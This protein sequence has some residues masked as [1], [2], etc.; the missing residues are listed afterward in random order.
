MDARRVDIMPAG[1]AFSDTV[2]TVDDLDVAVA[3]IEVVAVDEAVIPARD[4]VAAY[5]VAG[6]D[7]DLHPVITHEKM[8]AAP[9]DLAPHI[10]EKVVCIKLERGGGIQIVKEKAVPE[11]DRGMAVNSVVAEVE[12]ADPFF[13]G[14]STS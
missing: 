14:E 8:P 10:V 3:V 11:I 1:M 5:P 13:K 2:V 12:K 4:S 9:Q 7:G 6:E